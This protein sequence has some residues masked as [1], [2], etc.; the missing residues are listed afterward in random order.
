M[1]YRWISLV[2]STPKVVPAPRKF[3]SYS[4]LVCT[5]Y[6]TSHETFSKP[7]GPHALQSAVARQRIPV[8]TIKTPQS[9]I[10][11][12]VVVSAI[13]AAAALQVPPL[14]RGCSADVAALRRGLRQPQLLRLRAGGGM[15]QGSGRPGVR[16]DLFRRHSYL[17]S[18]LDKFTYKSKANVSQLVSSLSRCISVCVHSLPRRVKLLFFIRLYFV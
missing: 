10:R 5:F 13:A 15:V 8:P 9:I 4:E 16:R 3:V 11:L 1:C 14:W 7:Y 17:L 2:F 18:T 6:H 12:T